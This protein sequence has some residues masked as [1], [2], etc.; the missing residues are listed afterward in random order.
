MLPISENDLVIAFDKSTS[1]LQMM[2]GG[3]ALAVQVGK[4]NSI[5]LTVIQSRAELKLSDVWRT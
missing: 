2:S 5:T 3:S 4:R 1:S